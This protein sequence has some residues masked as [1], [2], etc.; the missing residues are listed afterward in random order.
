MQCINSNILSGENDIKLTC[1]KNYLY[2]HRS[3]SRLKMDKRQSMDTLLNAINKSIL[4]SLGY[5]SI[6][7]CHLY[8]HIIEHRHF[9]MIYILS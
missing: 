2:I 5:C 1:N 8:P 9:N 4:P 6:K 3:I 7:Y